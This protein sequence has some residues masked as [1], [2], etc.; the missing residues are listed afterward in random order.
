MALQKLVEIGFILKFE[1]RDDK[2]H[3]V[4]AAKQFKAPIIRSVPQLES[5]V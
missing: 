4:R 2:V 1:I 3:I 5:M